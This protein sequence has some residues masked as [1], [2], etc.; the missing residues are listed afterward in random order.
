[1]EAST[2]DRQA[3]VHILC[4]DEVVARASDMAASLRLQKKRE[5]EEGQLYRVFMS[6][7]WIYLLGEADNSLV[8]RYRVQQEIIVAIS[9]TIFRFSMSRRRRRGE[10]REKEREERNLLT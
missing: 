1:M 8:H 2:T 4:I 7:N 10:M 9:I 5:E 3:D 6:T